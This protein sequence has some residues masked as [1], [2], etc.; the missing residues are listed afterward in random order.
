MTEPAKVRTFLA[1]PLPD[2]LKVSLADLSERLQKGAKFTAAHPSWVNPMNIHLTLK[3][4]GDIDEG[5]I[6]SLRGQLPRVAAAH[7]AFEVQVRGLGVFPT[8]QNP[9]VVWVGVRKAGALHRLAEGVES[10][11]GKQGWPP[12]D[13]EFSPH[14]TLARLKHRRGAKAF[15]DTVQSHSEW[16]IGPWAIDRMVLFQSCLKSSGAEHTVLSE[17]PLGRA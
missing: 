3:F 2:D 6:E 7:R 9:R 1:L 13:H 12:A 17:F 14:L 8:P 4:F 5:Q 15:M 10:A 11:L 16:E